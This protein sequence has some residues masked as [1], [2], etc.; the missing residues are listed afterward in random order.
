MIKA[1][2]ENGASSVEVTLDQKAGI[3]IESVLEGVP[4]NVTVGKSGKMM[5]KVDYK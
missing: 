4:L 5:I 3:D 2:K 1:G